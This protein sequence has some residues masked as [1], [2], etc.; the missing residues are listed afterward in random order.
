MVCGSN[1]RPKSPI[2]ERVSF[3]RRVLIKVFRCGWITSPD[4]R[5]NEYREVSRFVPTD[6]E[7]ETAGAPTDHGV[8]SFN[9]FRFMM[10][11]GVAAQIRRDEDPILVTRV[12]PFDNQSASRQEF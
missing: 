12:P 6:L 4:R 3:A 9:G 8:S 10:D 7:P 2:I 11:R 5:R 1:H